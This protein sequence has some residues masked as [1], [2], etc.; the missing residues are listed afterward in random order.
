MDYVMENERFIKIGRLVFTVPYVTLDE[1]PWIAGEGKRF[2]CDLRGSLTTCVG[3]GS[4]D[5]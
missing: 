5:G 2:A 4:R 3:E 1:L